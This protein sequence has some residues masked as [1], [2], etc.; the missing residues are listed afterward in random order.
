M[1][2]DIIIVE[3]KPD[4]N[5]ADLRNIRL[6]AKGCRLVWSKLPCIEVRRFQI[7]PPGC[8]M[9]GGSYIEW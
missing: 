8:E 1:E 2:G 5:I 7:L 6:V 4:Q 3:G 9:E